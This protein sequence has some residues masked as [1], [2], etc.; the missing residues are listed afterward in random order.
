MNKPKRAPDSRKGYLC[1]IAHLNLKCFLTFEIIDIKRFSFKLII[2]ILI[3]MLKSQRKLFV[4]YVRCSC[5]HQCD[6]PEC[7]RL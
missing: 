5:S 4:D 1:D 6:H 2:R 7:C 3:S